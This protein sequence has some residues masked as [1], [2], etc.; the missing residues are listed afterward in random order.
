MNQSCFQSQSDACYNQLCRLFLRCNL[1]LDISSKMIIFVSLLTTFNIIFVASLSI[2]E[3]GLRQK[4][5]HNSQV[6]LVQISDAPVLKII[7]KCDFLYFYV[8]FSFSIFFFFHFVPC[9]AKPLR[10]L[11]VPAIYD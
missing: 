10:L 4:P 3:N 11:L 5:K 9:P 8:I 2:P 7:F 1:N 6:K